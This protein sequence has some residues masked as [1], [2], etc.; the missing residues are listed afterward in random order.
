MLPDGEQQRER[1]EFWSKGTRDLD[2]ARDKVSKADLEEMEETF[3]AREK[4]L[5]GYDVFSEVSCGLCS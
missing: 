1:D 2:K 5:L 4:W 3:L